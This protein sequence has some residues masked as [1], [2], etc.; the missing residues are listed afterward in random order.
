[1]DTVSSDTWAARVTA[2]AKLPDQ[3]LNGRFALFLAAL[4]AKPSDGIAQACGPGGPT[5][6]AYRFMENRRIM[7]RSLLDPVIQT[8]AESCLGLPMIYA[9]QDTTSLNYSRR[10]KTT[11]LGPISDSPARGLHVH[12]TLAVT[13][14]GVVIGLLGQ[15][16]WARHNEVRTSEE[17]RHRPISEKESR[18]WLDGM[19]AVR[20]A[21]APLP[22]EQ[23]PRVVHIMDREGDIHEVFAEVLAHHE[24]AIIRCGQDRRVE[25]AGQIMLSRAAVRASPCLGMGAIDVPRRGAQAARRASV[26]YRAVHLRLTPDPDHNPGRSPLDLNLVEVWE[27][28]PPE[29]VEALH[30]L[31]WT[32]EPIGTLEE[33]LKAV[34][35]YRTRWVIEEL[36]LTLKSGC[37]IEGLQLETAE[38]LK[39]AII[40]YSAVAAR[41]VRLRDVSRLTPDAPCTTELSEDE[42]RV[43]WAHRHHRPPS[44][45]AEPPTLRDAVRWI[46]QLGGHMGRKSD[47]MPGV[48]TLWLGWRDLQLLVAGYRATRYER[49]NE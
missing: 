11:G 36:H 5:K 47:G 7:P 19:E 3:R 10:S 27:P 29:G 48:R 46:G 30:W 6:A 38:R 14:E 9:V 26:E 20:Q 49:R 4:A 40:L 37:Q 16:I 1:M 42:W 28:H 43:L 41:I 35:A 25:I 31:L 21:L 24:S 17:R 22:P 34:A 39:K 23:R 12:T 44:E 13:P 18:K 8:T 15:D 33:V 32:T 2:R 45:V